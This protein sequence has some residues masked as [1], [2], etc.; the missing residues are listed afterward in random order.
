MDQASQT[1]VVE[2]C[3]AAGD[4]LRLDILR[5]LSKDSFGVQELAH[6]LSVPQPLMSHHLK[7][8]SKSGLLVTRRQGNSIFYRRALLKDAFQGSLYQTID[9][10][11][12][13][14][15][16]AKKIEAVHKER[17]QQSRHYFEKNVDRFEENQGLLCEISQYLPNLKELLDLMRLP[18][19]ARIMEVG[20]GQ[21]VL[22]EEL[23]KRYQNIVALDKS[24]GMLALTRENVKG[25][26]IEYV[27]ESLESYKLAGK[28]FDAIVL[29]MVLHH[30]AS[31]ERAFQ[32]LG[33][34]T[35][36]YVLIADLCLHDQEWT[37]DSC[38]DIWLGFDPN[39]MTDWAR[40]SGFVE[41]HHSYLG[42]K[43]GFQIQLKLFCKEENN[44][45]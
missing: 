17:S 7:I 45:G 43:N 13:K 34:L 37:R 9:H 40:D 29:N 22:L 31:P 4:P 16:Q 33:S 3:K 20:P 2:V 41:K 32:K 42:L 26:K 25:K 28:A 21:G 18:K 14:D 35:K 44:H 30:M 10:S 8:L 11:P 23:A 24:E 1:N 5:V 12:L 6:I 38:G 39:E 36:G 19:E 27:N 15:P